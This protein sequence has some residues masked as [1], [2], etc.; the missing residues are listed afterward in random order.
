MSLVVRGLSLGWRS[1]GL[2]H[3]PRPMASLFDP[4]WWAAQLFLGWKLVAHYL[5]KAWPWAPRYGFARFQ[6]NYVAE[7]LPPSSAEFRL[8]AHEPGRCTTCGACDA[9]CPILRGHQRSPVSADFLGPMGFVISG[10]RGAPH[11][12]DVK[13]TLDVL[14][15]PLCEGCR[16]CDAA[17]PERIP[18][19][20]LAA[21]YEEQRAVVERARQGQI[22]IADARRAL[23]PWV[24]RG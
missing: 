17:C 9:V 10:A 6:E 1:I 19:A 23:P 8:L 22:P 7:G 20:K 21:V 12:A 15:G 5:K 18:I 13:V 2:S 16:A 14:N 3:M 4:R 24:G 11:L